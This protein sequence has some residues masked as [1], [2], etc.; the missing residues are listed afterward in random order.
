MVAAE[1]KAP[2]KRERDN[3]KEQHDWS[4]L[5]GVEALSTFASL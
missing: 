1:V 5:P 2:T 3:E 4:A